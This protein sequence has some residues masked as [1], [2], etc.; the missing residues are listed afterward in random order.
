MGAQVSVNR[1]KCILQLDWAG[2]ARHID[3]RLRTHTNLARPE[4]YATHHVAAE[5]ITSSQRFAFPDRA[6]HEQ[7]KQTVPWFVRSDAQRSASR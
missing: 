4:I 6:P 7:L 2:S 1:L 3:L 5:L